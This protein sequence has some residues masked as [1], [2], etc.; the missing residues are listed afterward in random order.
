MLAL[1]PVRFGLAG[2][3]LSGVS[4]F[5]ITLFSLATG[6]GEDY[7]IITMSIFPGFAITVGG[8]LLGLLYGFAFG[9]AGLFLLGWIYN[10][11][12]PGK[13]KE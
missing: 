9:F 1:D 3:L 10:L 8:S 7:L 2:G 6:Y 12:G 4:M 5:L 11:L 13:E